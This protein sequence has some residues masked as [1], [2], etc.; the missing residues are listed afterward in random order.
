MRRWSLIAGT[1]SPGAEDHERL[2]ADNRSAAAEAVDDALQVVNIFDAH[3]DERVRVACGGED[4]ADFADVL[5][6]AGDV[7]DL[8]VPA[9]RSSQKAPSGQPSLAWSIVIV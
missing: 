7:V 9:K 6:D 8:V 4:G 2:A 1:W 5:G 3:P